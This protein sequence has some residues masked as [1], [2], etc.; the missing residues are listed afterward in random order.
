MTE[1]L[2]PIE[3]GVL[4]P[5]QRAW[6]ADNAP[7]K[8]AEKSRR[9]GLTWAEAAD[10]AVIAAKAKDAGGM[11]V[12]YCGYNRDM[13][14]EFIETVANWA[15]A[16]QAAV[17]ELGVY[18]EDAGEVLEQS[19]KDNGICAF[20]IRFASGFKVVALSSRPSNFRGKQGVA[21]LDEFAFHGDQKELLKAALAFLIWGGKVRII[22]THDGVENEFNELITQIRAKKRRYSLHRIT[23]DEA[24]EQGLAVRALSR[25][26]KP[27]TPAAVKAWS[28]EIYEL[29]GDDADEE[30]R[31]IPR[32]SN[33]VYLPSA[34][35]EQRMRD[36]IPVLR[37]EP[38]DDFVHWSR[39]RREAHALAWCEEHVEV[40]LEELDARCPTFVGEDFGRVADL[41]V[42]WLLT[43]CAD[44]V[45]RTPLV[46][47]LRNVPF[48]QQKQILWFICDRLPR[49]GGA[50]LDAGGNGA[51]VAETT[52]QRYGADLIQQIRFSE[53]WYR[54]NMPKYKSAYEDGTIEIPKNGDI[55]ADHRGIRV[56]RGVARVP[57]VRIAGGDRKKRHCD[58]AIAGALAYFATLMDVIAHEGYQAAPR[59]QPMDEAGPSDD[60]DGYFDAVRGGA[61]AARRF[62]A[63]A[64]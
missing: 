55:L 23:F 26:K 24:V 32:A 14:L 36:G 47:E 11:D 49:F 6:I 45:R 39:E 13:A 5:Y 20:K 40:L 50:A 17:E 3:A 34:L 16:Y 51:D 59:E 52:M 60:D 35:I 31:V 29:Y 2:S 42:I 12:W 62:G 8:L 64:Y 18:I 61:P 28:D 58:S 38:P 22:S 1:T 15:R 19:D 4:L 21:V 9:I 27:A 25:Q 10:D 7:V 43:L 46:V 48:D 53:Q 33:Q 57:D 30:L 41:T 37:Y 56:I 63:G 44:T 54:E